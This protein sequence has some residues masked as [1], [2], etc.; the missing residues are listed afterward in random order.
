M[1]YP[2]RIGVTRTDGEESRTVE[3]SDPADP[4]HTYFFHWGMLICLVSNFTVQSE[5]SAEAVA[6]LFPE[7]MVAMGKML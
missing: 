3:E 1:T 4:P 7:I 5:C 2:T 6:H